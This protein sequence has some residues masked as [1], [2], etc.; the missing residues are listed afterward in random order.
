M[1]DKNRVKYNP[2]RRYHT[3][4]QDYSIDQGRS[5]AGISKLNRKYR[6]CL[7]C[8][9]KFLSQGNHNRLCDICA[10]KNSTSIPEAKMYIRYG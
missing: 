6:T 2:Q 10:Y 7:R 5:A 8:D 1:I 3:Q 9:T 4:K